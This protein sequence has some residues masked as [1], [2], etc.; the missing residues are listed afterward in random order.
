[1]SEL[2][3]LVS[4]HWLAD[5][6]ENVKIVDSTF[7][8]PTEQRDPH[9]EFIK[10]HIPGAVFFD[11]D[12]IADDSSP[13]PHMFPSAHKFAEEVGKLGISERDTLV[14]YDSGK[15]SGAC[16]AWWMFR[17]F[18]Q[19]RVL[20]LNGGLKK[21]LS[22][23]RPTQSGPQE[24]EPVNYQARFNAAMLRSLAEVRK[25]LQSGSDQVLDARSAGRFSGSEAE[26]RP[27]MRSGHMPGALNLPYDHLINKDGTFKPVAELEHLFLRSGLSDDKPVITSCGSGIS[28]ATLLMGLRLIGREDTA[29]YDG[30]WAEWGSR[31]D[32]P[33][34]T[35]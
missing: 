28:A 17:A 15:S 2:E 26:P 6:L 9:A 12:K 18:G 4:T 3:N 11:I 13:L 20:V 32:T 30:S 25:A 35:T 27:G 24:R 19:R 5:H 8:L 23:Q 1:M 31:D 7:Y 33:V 21:W 34:A 29:L 14:C 22:E 10:A 16:R